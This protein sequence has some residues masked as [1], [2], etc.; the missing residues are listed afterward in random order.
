M[1]GR[2]GHTYSRRD[3]L[4][5]TGTV[6]AGGVSMSPLGSGITRA[7]TTGTA[8]AVRVQNGDAE[9]IPAD[10]DA[11]FQQPYL[12]YKPETRF[13]TARP[14]YVHPHNRPPVRTRDELITQMEQA[15]KGP[16]FVAKRLGL[17]GLLPGIPRLPDDGPDLMQT[18]ALPTIQADGYLED[19]AID[20]FPA[21]SLE[22]IDEQLISMIDDAME[23]L[24]AEDYSVTDQVHM[25]GFSASSTFSG[26]FAFL[27]PDRV[28]AFT[29]GGSGGHP[30]PRESIDGTT[31]QYPLG[32]ADYAT[33]TGRDF[34][35]ESWKTINQY[36]YVGQEDQ[37][38]PDTEQFGY[39][40][41]S[42]R[43]QEKAETVYGMN[44][45]T[46]RIPFLKT[47]YSAAGAD[48]T[49]NVYDGI[50]HTITNEIIDD[51]VRVH[52]DT[53]DAP[54]AMFNMTAQ[55]VTT[56]QLTAGDAVT[57]IVEI[58][59]RVSRTATFPATLFID[60]DEVA[61]AET[62][63]P[64]SGTDELRLEYTFADPGTYRVTVN[65]MQVGDGPFLVTE[66]TP[67]PTTTPTATAT[68]TAPATDTP[69]GTATA[70]PTDTPGEDGPGFGI[71]LALSGLAGAGYL[72]SNR[73]EDRQ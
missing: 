24:S 49:F 14:L 69:A 5:A 46:E 59:S 25:N 53:S 31:L 54:H 58:E 38:L 2:F 68:T 30:L 8:H 41:I 15:A 23:R 6:L 72:L 60:G 56:D 65:G 71:G 33:I 16:F 32:T 1:S 43:D 11:G 22:R 36:I 57:I 9:I 61:A 63:V 19:I 67:T 73:F 18:L 64:A 50:G 45:A 47:E 21:E 34:D 48:A 26:R 12:L 52:R 4:Q 37:P 17:P 39:Y 55:R 35:V 7:R 10:P 13:N 40:G 20:E 28:N 62:E 29:A 42:H 66:A 44:R 3:V 51:V 70:A 27:Y